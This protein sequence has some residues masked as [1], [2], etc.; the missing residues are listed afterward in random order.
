MLVEH[1][2]SVGEMKGINEFFSPKAKRK[3]G[4]VKFK[5]MMSLNECFILVTVS[6]RKGNFL[7]AGKN[8][9]QNNVSRWPFTLTLIN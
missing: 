5:G 2:S 6:S 8:E 9:K 1:C 4:K 3:Q 7:L